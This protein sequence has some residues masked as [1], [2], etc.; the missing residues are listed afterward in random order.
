[1]YSAVTILLSRTQQDTILRE[2]CYLPSF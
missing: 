2:W 1:L